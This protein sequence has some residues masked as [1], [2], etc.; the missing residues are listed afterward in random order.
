MGDLIYLDNAATSH[1]KPET[2]YR[3]IDRFLRETSANPG[4]SSHRRAVET[5]R[6]IWESRGELARWFGGDSPERLIF[7]L[8]CTDALNMAIK[9]CLRDGDHVVTSTLEHN[10]VSRPLNRLERLGRISVTRVAPSPDGF[11]DP[12]QIAAAVRPG[13]RLVAIL[14]ASNVLGTVQ[15]L[16][17]IG[18]RVREL[19]PLFLVD[20]AQSAGVLP[21]DCGRF[22]IDMLAFTGHKGLLGP[23][24]VG[25]LYL[26]ERAILEPWREGG[27][28]GDSALP[29]Q[30]EE[31]P[32]RLEAGTPNSAGIAGLSA[33]LAFLGSEGLEKIHRREV[34]LRQILVERLSREPRIRIYSPDPVN[35]VGTL[36]LNVKGYEPAEVGAILDQAFGIAV[37]TGLHCAP[38]AHRHIGTFPGGTVR[39]S[40]GCFNTEEEIDK[41]ASA[42]LEISRSRFHATDESG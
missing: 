25:G 16:E 8:N 38:G 41:A 17:G 2:V 4:R 15:D 42:L 29:E 5:A 9:G 3:A 14:H 23:V 13:T 12:D 22:A 30:P 27:T 37:R 40:I 28:G 32:M 21:I 11:L 6:S 18:R 34:G 1:P 20:S 10:S 7:T 36:S 24:G 31:M 33:A 35:V 39:L 19:G 26:S